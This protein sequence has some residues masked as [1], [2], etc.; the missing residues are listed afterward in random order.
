MITPSPAKGMACVVEASGAAH[1]R[2]QS[3]IAALKSQNA[4]GRR[5]L[6]NDLMRG[7]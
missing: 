4:I 2:P 6:A 5:H 7:I 1:E 3:I